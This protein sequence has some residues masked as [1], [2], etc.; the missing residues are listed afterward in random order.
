MYGLSSDPKMII[1]EIGYILVQTV[2][3]P[4]SC[5]FVTS[6]PPM[7]PGKNS[8]EVFLLAPSGGHEAKRRAAQA[9]VAR[10]RRKGAFS[11]VLP[12]RVYIECKNSH[13]LYSNHYIDTTY[14]YSGIPHDETFGIIPFPAFCY[15]IFSSYNIFCIFSRSRRD[16]DHSALFLKLTV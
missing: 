2:F 5:H 12:A 11:G 15:R 14:L 13:C 10:Q 8:A 16:R 6:F 7:G 1:M 9:Q 4:P 3:Q